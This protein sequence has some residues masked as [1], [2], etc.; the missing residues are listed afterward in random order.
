MLGIDAGGDGGVDGDDSHMM[1]IMAMK[2]TTRV[3]AMMKM[4]VIMP[5]MLQIGC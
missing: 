1:R 3:H 4:R 2:M 5:T